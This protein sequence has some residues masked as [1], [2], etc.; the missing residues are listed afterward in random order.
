MYKY[1]F[2]IDI[3]ICGHRIVKIPHPVRSAKSSTI[4][5][6]QYCGGGPRGNPG[7][8]S[9]LFASLN[10][11]TRATQLAGHLDHPFCFFFHTSAKEMQSWLK[12]TSFIF[13]REGYEH[14]K[15]QE[16]TSWWSR[17]ASLNIV[18]W[19]QTPRAML[20]AEFLFMQQ[21]YTS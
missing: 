11:T 6:S 15:A 2:E 18:G 20:W 3:H 8:C 21:L 12:K 16:G 9:F 4:S 17:H 1:P 14:C 19:V 7:C 13:K 10:G 5:P